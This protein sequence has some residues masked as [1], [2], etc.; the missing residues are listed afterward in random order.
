ML[1]SSTMMSHYK[2]LQTRADTVKKGLDD[3]FYKDQ[4]REII[5]YKSG[6]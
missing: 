2:C 5:S 6:I 1:T 4:I 3:P